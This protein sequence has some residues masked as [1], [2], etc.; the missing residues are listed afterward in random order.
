M[1][2]WDCAFVFQGVEDK[3]ARVHGW[4]TGPFVDQ[5]FPEFLEA[6]SLGKDTAGSRDTCLEIIFACN[7]MK[8]VN[9]LLY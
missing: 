3:L 8:N 2:S 4:W 7:L 1:T 6:S 5:A 9:D